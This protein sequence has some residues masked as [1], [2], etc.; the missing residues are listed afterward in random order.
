MDELNAR[1]E[2]VVRFHM[3]EDKPT[4]ETGRKLCRC[5]CKSFGLR[6]VLNVQLARNP[7][8]LCV[9]IW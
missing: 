9:A 3:S 2:C 5:V 4:L 7:G 6:E 1:A 8:L